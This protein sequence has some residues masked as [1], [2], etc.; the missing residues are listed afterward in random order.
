MNLEKETQKAI[1]ST[2]KQLELLKTDVEE[3]N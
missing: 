2:K 3:H 1:D